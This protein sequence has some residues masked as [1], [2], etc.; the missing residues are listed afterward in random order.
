MQ[1]CRKCNGLLLPKKNK[2]VLYCRVCNEEQP[3]ESDGTFK[4]YKGVKGSKT[5]K[6]FKDT[7][8]NR[9]AIIVDDKKD[10]SITE[11]D[12]ETYEDYFEVDNESD[13]EGGD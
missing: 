13:Y 3:I 4:K 2:K 11:E 5:S 10:H 12:R 7:R 6:R 1:Y 9:T 8:A